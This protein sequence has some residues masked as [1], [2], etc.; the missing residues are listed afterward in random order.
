V[1]ELKI[2]TDLE[3]PVYD[4]SRSVVTIGAFDGIHRGHVKILKEVAMLAR[5]I[6]GR[7]VVVTFDPH[8]ISV[9]RPDERPCLLTGPQEKAALIEGTGADDLVIVDFTPKLA[10]RSADWFLE[11]VLLAKLGLRRLVIGYDFRFGKS[12]EGDAAYLERAGERLGFGVDIVPP[13]LF[14]DH[15]VSSTRIRTAL[16]RGEVEVAAEM[17]G[18]P[19]SLSGTVVKGE[20]RGQSLDY[21]TANLKVGDPGKMVPPDGVYAVTAVYCGKRAAGALYIGIRPTYGGRARS[22]EVYVI[23][24]AEAPEY[25]GALA[26]EFAG[27]VRGEMTFEDDAALKAQIAEDVDKIRRIMGISP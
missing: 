8:P 6:E 4:D 25:G 11:E 17:L 27:R 9:V 14:M 7:G 19:Y 15:P 10:S 2:I 22:I 24:T 16:A 1:S 13:L 18:R 26:I 23:D 3:R 12:R 5:G 21:P 20:G